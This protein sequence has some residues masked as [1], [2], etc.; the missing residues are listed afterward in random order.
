M[1]KFL[2]DEEDVEFTEEPEKV[3]KDGGHMEFAKILKANPYHDELGRF[4]TQDK[5]KFVSVG[6]VFDKQRAKVSTKPR[7]AGGLPVPVPDLKKAAGHY[8]HTLNG[9]ATTA[10]ASEFYIKEGDKGVK[11]YYESRLKLPNVTFDPDDPRDVEWVNQLQSS[12]VLVDAVREAAPTEK[13]LFRGM[14]HP[15]GLKFLDDLT[16]GSELVHDR[17]TSYS[18]DMR[19][20]AY[21]AGGKND[22]RYLLEIRGK[23]K[24]LATDDMTGLNHKEHITLGKFKVV[25]IKKKPTKSKLPPVFAGTVTFDRHIVLEW[26]EK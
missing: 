5:A 12:K 10:R 18:E 11:D 6:G 25:E 14:W 24:T 19:Q 2:W 7:S 23:S 3:E 17:L 21:Y 8:A 4:S 16:E 22:Y 13:S 20:A 1:N 26:Q 15:Q 9:G